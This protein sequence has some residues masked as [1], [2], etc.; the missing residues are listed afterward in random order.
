M[1]R[2]TSTRPTGRTHATLRALMRLRGLPTRR[3]EIFVVPACL[4][5]RPG[6]APLPDWFL[7]TDAMYMLRAAK[8]EARYTGHL[9]TCE[10]CQALVDVALE[11]PLAMPLYALRWSGWLDFSRSWGVLECDAPAEYRARGTLV[12]PRG[13]LV[14]QRG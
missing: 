1:T 4:N 9:P 5:Q 7:D 3:D 11:N 10:E 2:A 13:T 12:P 6:D 8:V 14:P